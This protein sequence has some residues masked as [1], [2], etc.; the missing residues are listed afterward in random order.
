MRK[1]CGGHIVRWGP[2]RDLQATLRALF[3]PFAIKKKKKANEAY[4][5]SRT[6][7]SERSFL[8]MVKK[9][10]EIGKVRGYRLFH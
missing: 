5:P 2:C 8:A 9:G 3:I 6:R 4:V 10:L 7:S 1:R